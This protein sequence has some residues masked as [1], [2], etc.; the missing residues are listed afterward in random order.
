[1][2]SYCFALKYMYQNPHTIVFGSRKFILSSLVNFFWRHTV[3]C[4]SSALLFSETCI[5]VEL[6]MN[7]E[8]L[9]KNP[10]AYF[11]CPL[12]KPCFNFPSL[13]VLD[14]AA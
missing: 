5:F 4:V 3:V 14:I 10:W 7:C 1:M 12:H 13:A 9:G 2:E 8:R 6:A 11:V